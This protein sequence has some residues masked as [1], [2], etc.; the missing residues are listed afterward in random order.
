MRALLFV[1]AL[2]AAAPAFA[3]SSLPPAALADTQLADP[4]QE[5]QAKALMETIRC[6]VCQGQ[7]IADS[8]AEMAGDMRDLV[9]RR[10]QAGE[11]PESIRAWLIQ[12]YGNWV[13]YDPPL[14][15]VTWPLWGL[16]A[17]LV[18]AGLWLARGRFKPRRRT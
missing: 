16:P 10:I 12:R 7:S 17:I 11:S 1:L 4:R 3:D 14:E 18:L 2:A 13:S 9:R 15:P 5:R 8:D 6:L